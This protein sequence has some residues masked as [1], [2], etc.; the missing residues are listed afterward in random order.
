M[1]VNCT[2]GAVIAATNSS[3]SAHGTR[4]SLGCFP[5]L[6]CESAAADNPFPL[7]DHMYVT[8]GQIANRF[9]RSRRPGEL[10]GI[11][12]GRSRQS[13]VQAKVVLRIIAGAAPHLVDLAA[14]AAGDLD[15]GSDCRSVRSRS[16]T[17]DQDRMMC[18]GAVVAQQRRR[19]VKIIDDDIHIAVVVEVAEGAA[20]PEILGADGRAGPCR[21]VFKPAVAEIAVDD[22]RLPIAEMQVAAGELRVDVTVGDED[23][24]P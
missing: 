15:A 12:L 9:L 2:S 23:V 11:S 7:L 17:L 4:Q 18:G 5:S 8:G 3:S 19:S 13:E 6:L 20:A 14:I 1:S 21:H 10:D 24:L 16:D 22:L